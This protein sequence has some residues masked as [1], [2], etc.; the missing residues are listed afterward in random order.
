[1]RSLLRPQLGRHHRLQI[2]LPVVLPPLLRVHDH[3]PCDQ[4]Y[5]ALSSEVWRGVA[6]VREEGALAVRA[7]E[8]C[9]FLR[10]LFR[11]GAVMDA[12]MER[13]GPNFTD[14]VSCVVRPLNSLRVICL[15]TKARLGFSTISGVLGF[16]DF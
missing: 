11:E 4:G 14:L 12:G 1:V 7:G 8:F 16:L 10:L 15:P 6:G 9:S 3:P 2:P 5:P 13:F